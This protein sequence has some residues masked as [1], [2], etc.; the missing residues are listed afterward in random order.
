MKPLL[1]FGFSLIVAGACSAAGPASAQY[2][3]TEITGCDGGVI[4][5]GGL[6]RQAMIA[7]DCF[8]ESGNPEFVYAL[9]PFLIDRTGIHQLGRVKG[10]LMVSPAGINH[11][12]EVIAN[13]R[14]PDPSRAYLMQGLEVKELATLGGDWNVAYGINESGDVVGAAG[15]PDGTGHA[16]IYQNGVM[17]DLGAF[18]ATRSEAT[19]IN[20]KGQIVINRTFGTNSDAVITAAIY[21]H[22]ALEPVVFP[23]ARDTMGT[24]INLRGRVVGVGV[25]TNGDIFF[26]GSHLLTH[27]FF[28]HDGTIEDLHS[29]FFERLARITFTKSINDQDEVVGTWYNSFDAEEVYGGFLYRDGVVV[30]VE[31][32]LPA[33]SGWSVKTAEYINN[34][35]QIIGAGYYQGMP[36]FYLLSPDPNQRQKTQ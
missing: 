32:L 23:E 4:E 3:I 13:R 15:L 8:V 22:G 36:R 18:D 30:D 29:L 27:A 12:G 20:G 17:R 16:F 6:T 33:N 14:Y 25:L 10:G 7:A 34:A 31:G 11:R 21:S 24:A 28:Y 26:D 1:L 9:V 19:A 2:T 5:V 35:G